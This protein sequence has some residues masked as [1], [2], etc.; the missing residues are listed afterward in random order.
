MEGKQAGILLTASQTK[1]QIAHEI[2]TYEQIL[3]DIKRGCHLC[4]EG[5]N[6]VC[7]MKSNIRCQHR[8]EQKI[9]AYISRLQEQKKSMEGRPD[10]QIYWVENP[11]L[12][13]KIYMVTEEHDKDV[14]T[15]RYENHND[16]YEW[17]SVTIVID[18][19]YN[20]QEIN[21][22]TNSK[23]LTSIKFDDHI[24]ECYI[25]DSEE[26]ANIAAMY[27]NSYGH[28]IICP[29]CGRVKYFDRSYLEHLASKYERFSL[30]VRCGECKNIR[31]NNLKAK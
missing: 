13:Q 27:M 3:R 10:L 7:N 11:G 16:K 21:N 8:E 23:Y 28:T 4:R 19:V 26:S 2:I 20:A 9:E 29:D 22:V 6:G 30:P 5:N 17:H 1:L 18:T 14:F 12:C 31:Q 25:Y 24:D 15:I